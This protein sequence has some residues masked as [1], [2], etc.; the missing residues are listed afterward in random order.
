MP[1]FLIAGAG[2]GGLCA[3]LHL[4]KAGHRATVF[5]RLAEADLGYDWPDTVWADALERSGFT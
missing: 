3:A 4:A 2:H 5:E 1:H